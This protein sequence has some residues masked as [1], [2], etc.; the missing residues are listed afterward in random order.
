MNGNSIEEEAKEDI[1]AFIGEDES[2]H[3]F[4]FIHNQVVNSARYQKF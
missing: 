3:E 4:K 2:S 1:E